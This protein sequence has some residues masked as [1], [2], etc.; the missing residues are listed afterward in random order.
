MKQSEIQEVISTEPT[1]V[2]SIDGKY[3]SHYII[4]GF[5]KEAKYNNKYG[6]PMT[7]A[8]TQQ[9]HFDN[10]TNTTRISTYVQKKALRVVNGVFSKSIDSYNAH[11]I[12]MAQ[13]IANALIVKQQNQNA[14]NEIKPELASLLKEL[15]I[16]NKERNYSSSATTFKIELDVDNANQLI[17][18]LNTI[19]FA[20][21][22]K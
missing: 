5:V 10:K 20:K 7:Y 8:V 15:N 12:E 21:A 1:A 2:F 3:D 17:T 6:K 16:E 19:T 22:G 11:K 13:R 4:T 9:V 14:M 18:L